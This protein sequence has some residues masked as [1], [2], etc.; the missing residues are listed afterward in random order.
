[1]F[2]TYQRRTSRR[3]LSGSIYA[4]LQIFGILLVTCLGKTMGSRLGEGEVIGW[5]V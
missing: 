5:V 1:M 4:H 2:T 3:L